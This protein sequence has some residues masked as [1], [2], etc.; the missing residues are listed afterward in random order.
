MITP[1]CRTLWAYWMVALACVGCQLESGIRPRT[2]VVVDI[3]ADR[4]LRAEIDHVHLTI[5]GSSTREQLASAP[6]LVDRTLFVRMPA[7]PHWPLREVLVPQGADATRVYAMT[8]TG[9]NERGRLVTEVHVESGYVRDEIRSMQLNLTAACIGVA[10]SQA[11]SCLDGS[12]QDAWRSPWGLPNFTAS[13]DDIPWA[14]RGAYIGQLDADAHADDAGVP[15]RDRDA[16][17]DERQRSGAR[18]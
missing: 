2:Q 9:L 15:A 12:C 4:R 5:V 13:E 1:M 14:N 11:E 7:G 17:A 18:P 16:G 3:D 10:C 8:V 6:A